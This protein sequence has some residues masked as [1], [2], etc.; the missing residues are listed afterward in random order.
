LGPENIREKT[1]D[2]HGIQE[3]STQGKREMKL[4]LMVI[5]GVVENDNR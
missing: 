3:I 4:G 1:K 5:F 2:E